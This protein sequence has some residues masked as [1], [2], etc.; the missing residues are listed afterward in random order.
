MIVTIGDIQVSR[1][2]HIHAVRP[3]KLSLQRIARVDSIALLTGSGDRY[4]AAVLWRIFSNEVVLR[5]RDDHV[6]LPVDTEMLGPVHVRRD[7]SRL[8]ERPN[9]AL[10]I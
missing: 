8:N 2:I 1:W 5:V 10:P 7:A 4:R 3:V 9:R 6:V